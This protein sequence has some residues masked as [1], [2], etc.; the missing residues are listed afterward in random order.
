MSVRRNLAPILAK[1]ARQYPVVTVTGPRQ[2]GKTTLCKA[3]FPKKPYVTF[4]RLDERERAESDPRGSHAHHPGGATPYGAIRDGDWRL[5]EFYED[6]HVE[7][8]H[9]R[10]DEGEQHDLAKQ[11]PSRAAAF[12]DRLHAWRKEVGAQVPTPNPNYDEAKNQAPRAAAKK[13]TKAK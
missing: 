8:Y 13:Q 1:V 7:L 9:L 3:V 2:A 5:V 12:R 10:D 11:D 6:N 4:E